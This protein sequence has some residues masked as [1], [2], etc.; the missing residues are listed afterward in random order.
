MSNK[1][2]RKCLYVAALFFISTLLSACQKQAEFISE[3]TIIQSRQEEISVESQIDIES[4]Y[5]FSKLQ[6]EQYKE[7]YNQIYEALRNN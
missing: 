3:Q 5:Y 6:S 7:T 1:K 2:V 4:D